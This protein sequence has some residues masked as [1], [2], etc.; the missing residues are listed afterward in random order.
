MRSFGIVT[1][2]LLLAGSLTGQYGRMVWNDEF[3]GITGVPDPSKWSYEIGNGCPDNCGWGNNQLEYYTDA[4]MNSR[5]EN[6]LLIIEAHRQSMGGLLYSSA[7]I[8][9]RQSGSWKYG[10]IDVRARLPRGRGTW[11]AIWMLPTHWKYGGWPHSGEIDIMEHV[12]W[13]QDSL[14][15]TVHTQNYNHVA[16]TQKG[17]TIHVPDISLHFHVYSIIWDKDKIDFLIDDKKYFTF[18]NDGRG[19]DSWPFDQEFYL[20]LNVAVGGN[21][22]GVRGVDNEIWP[23]RMEVDY[24][25]VYQ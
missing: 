13:A 10:R 9:T 3:D 6:G 15:G 22:G 7:K 25:R 8:N 24:V 5:I 21:F 4:S 1:L 18:D 23:Q 14:F 17:R 19:P 2:C 20:I 16:G 12:G 11:P